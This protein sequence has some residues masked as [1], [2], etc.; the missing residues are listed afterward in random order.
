[1]HQIEHKSFNPHKVNGD[2]LHLQTW[3]DF[4]MYMG[5]LPLRVMVNDMIYYVFVGRLF[6]VLM[7]YPKRDATR[8]PL[9]PCVTVGWKPFSSATK[10]TVHTWPS[11]STQVQE[12]VTYMASFSVPTFLSS[13][14]S[15]RL[16]PSD[17]SYLELKYLIEIS[18]N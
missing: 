14:F 9:M 2:F 10:V 17:S 6:F 18:N 13:P 8:G 5:L 4:I 1:M 15:S 3:R 12:P 16:V 7:V 11:G